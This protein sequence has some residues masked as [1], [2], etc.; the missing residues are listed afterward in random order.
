MSRERY[1]IRGE[2]SYLGRRYKLYSGYL[3]KRR[4]SCDFYCTTTLL[5]NAPK[6]AY[7]IINEGHEMA[8]HGCDYADSQPDHVIESFYRD[9]VSYC[10]PV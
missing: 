3:E 10:P 6:L 4:C 2:N 5:L 8:S 1:P 7:R 9:K